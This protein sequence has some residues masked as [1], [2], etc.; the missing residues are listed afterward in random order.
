MMDGWLSLR[1]LFCG[2]SIVEDEFFA[3]KTC[4]KKKGEGQEG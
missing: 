3:Q 4:E 1:S 2:H